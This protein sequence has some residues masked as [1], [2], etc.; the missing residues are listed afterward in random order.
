[1]SENDLI[2]Q[3][4]KLAEPGRGPAIIQ[5][6]GDDCAVIRPPR[7]RDL[8]FTTDFVLQNRHFT[9][10]THTPA[11]IGHKAL[12][13]S[14][15]DLAAMGAEP[16]FCL[17]SLAVPSQMAENFVPQFYSGLLEL[18]R[19]HS[20]SLAGGDLASFPDVIADVM[21][22][23]SVPRGKAFLR[24]VAQPGDQIYITGRLGY[25]AL[26]FRLKAGPAWDRHRCPTPRIKV[27]LKLRR[28]DVHCAMDI[29]DGLSL[30]LARLCT[31]SKV[32]ADLVSAALAIAPGA[33]LD[34]ALH[35][36]EDYEL[37]FTAPAR[38]KIPASISG[39]P[40]TMIGRIKEQQAALVTLDGTPLC[41]RGFDHFV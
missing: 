14:L 37:L 34:D 15:S 2:H 11:E 36:G 25:S 1:M 4:R 26:G 35:G 18:A 31:E 20:V 23:G 39:L 22:C 6:I 29:S 33:T 38:K 9:L 41:E 5:S 8:V 24:S 21:C 19:E 12:A 28:L 40:I 13:R 30:D 27:A 7:T 10:D 17:V 16:L 32:S 3:I